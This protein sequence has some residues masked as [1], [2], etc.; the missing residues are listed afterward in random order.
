MNAYVSKLVTRKQKI[1]HQ[2]Q[3]FPI[4]IKLNWNNVHK[5][6]KLFYRE[7]HIL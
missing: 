2:D 4:P 5:L 6:K 3:T 1:K 7:Y